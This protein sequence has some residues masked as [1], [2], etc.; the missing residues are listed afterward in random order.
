MSLDR[1]LQ[2]RSSRRIAVAQSSSSNSSTQI[3]HSAASKRL[4][5]ARAASPLSSQSSS[6]ER[7]PSS[8][9]SI[10]SQLHNFPDSQA[11]CGLH[12]KINWNNIH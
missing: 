4:Q 8:T 2:N 5:K 9:I 12:F 6:C 1:Y 3:N 7:T 10:S 11:N